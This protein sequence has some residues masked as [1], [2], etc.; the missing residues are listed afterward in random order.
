MIILD[1]NICI[2]L[3]KR[4][5]PSVLRHF[6]NYRPGDIA[7]SAIT[8][9]EL[10]YGVAKSQ[11]KERNKKA[12]SQFIIP[13]EVLPFDHAATVCY[14]QIRADLERKGQPIGA[15]DL[16]IAA[17]ALSLDALLVTNN[18]KEFARIEDLKLANWVE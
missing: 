9:A 1:T 4:K 8:L 13:L 18:M 14:G 16:L 5:P 7:I 6:Q 10:E 15:N 3:I 17:H 12:L 2:Y 11:A